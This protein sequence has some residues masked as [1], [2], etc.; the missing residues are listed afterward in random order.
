MN[1]PRNIVEEFISTMDVKGD[2]AF[3]ELLGYVLAK[4][5]RFTLAEAGTIF[6]C[7]PLLSDGNTRTLRCVSAQNDRIDLN[8]ASFVISIDDHSIAGYCAN[9]TK[10]LKIDDLY[11]ISAD[12]PYE[13]N[14]SF[15]KKDGYRS[16]SMLS[17]P[18]KNIKNEVIGV[19]QLLNRL[20][21]EENTYTPFSE[22]DEEHMH[23]LSLI[24]GM[25]VERTALMEENKRL[26]G[27]L[28]T[29]GGATLR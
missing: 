11:K 25:L 28:K 4:T 2:E 14:P 8:G 19:V 16:M 5:R 7:E 13:F 12:K 17:V 21:E 10:L 15:D 20:G 26:K 1:A 29:S 9:H 3:D 6:V 22:E 27:L 18:L 23:M 24:I